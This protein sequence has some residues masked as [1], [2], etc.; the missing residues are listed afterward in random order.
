MVFAEGGPLRISTS[1]AGGACRAAYPLDGRRLNPSPL[2]SI[3]IPTTGH[4]S[5]TGGIALSSICHE[6]TTHHYLLPFGPVL[7]SIGNV[8]QKDVTSGK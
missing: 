2:A 1:E 7:G 4:S 6:T 5:V 8:I 3:A